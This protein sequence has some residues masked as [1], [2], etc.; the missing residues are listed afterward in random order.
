MLRGRAGVRLLPIVRHQLDR[1]SR[2]PDFSAGSKGT[3]VGLDVDHGRAVDG[4]ETLQFERKSLHAN[5]STD[6]DPDPVG[7]ILSPLCEDS[8]RRPVCPPPRVAGA[9]MD[10]GL[11][12]AMQ[13]E[14]N[15]YM[16]ELFE[17][18]QTVGVESGGIQF[19]PDSTP[20]QA[21]STG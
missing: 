19:N 20:P 13:G 15:L 6:G 4:I 12:D 8:Y 10:V 1:P 14:D 11:G 2:L 3:H 16:R 21:R 17:P 5:Q 18:P 7:P 9:V